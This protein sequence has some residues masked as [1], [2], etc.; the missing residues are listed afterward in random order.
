MKERL[1]SKSAKSV[2]IIGGADGPT[3]IFIAGQNKKWNL[4]DRVKR[5]FYQKKR[6][7]VERSITAHPHTLEEVAQY[8]V[9]KYGAKQE[10]QQSHAY[11]EERSCL[12]ESLIIRHRPE[13]LGDL[14]QVDKPDR[15]DEEAMRE[16]WSKVEERSRRARGISDTQM[17]MDFHIYVIEVEQ[18]GCVRISMDVLWEIFGCSYSGSKQGMKQLQRIAKELYTYYGVTEADIQEQTERYRALVTTL[19][20]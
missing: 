9:D 11:I 10:S 20:S 17:P 1:T 4:K 5:Y 14:A 15:H 18:A 2:S 6:A 8:C 19:A 13:L 12:K 3:S 16:F 7:K